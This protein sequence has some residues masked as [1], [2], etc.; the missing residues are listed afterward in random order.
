MKVRKADI[1]DV[2]LSQQIFKKQAF[3]WKLNSIRSSQHWT[4]IDVCFSIC[5]FPLLLKMNIFM[6]AF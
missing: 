3:T 6:Y 2:K 4:I 1:T 5:E